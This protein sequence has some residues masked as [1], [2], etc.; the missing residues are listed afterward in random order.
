[1]NN[2]EVIITIVIAIVLLYIEYN[3]FG[4][5]QNI[6]SNPENEIRKLKNE[7]DSLNYKLSQTEQALIEEKQARFKAET[8]ARKIVSQE[9]GNQSH[10]I[11]PFSYQTRSQTLQQPS[12]C[13]N[14]LNRAEKIICNESSLW[15]FELKNVNI[16]N[17]LYNISNFSQRKN[18][19]RELHSWLRI[20]NKKCLRS[21]YT[22]KQVYQERILDLESR[23]Y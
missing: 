5:D 6:N 2:N 9:I 7:L 1:M 16:F 22:C 15:E 13:M 19:K 17:Q 8:K 21:V 3:Y 14:K 12:W 11:K 18:L 10:K 4:Q 23:L 20:R